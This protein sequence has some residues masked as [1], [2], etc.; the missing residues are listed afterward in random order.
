[1]KLLASLSDGFVIVCPA[2]AGS[3]EWA[4]GICLLYICSCTLF[5]AWNSPTV[6]HWFVVQLQEESDV[7]ASRI[8]I[9][10][11][12]YSSCGL[13]YMKVVDL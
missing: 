12:S 3:N 6:V 11:M 13:S 7:F 10:C 8:G 2:V 4:L 9:V 5:L 1:M